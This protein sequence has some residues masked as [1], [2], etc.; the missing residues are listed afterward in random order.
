M[1]GLYN[2]R[3]VKEL[4]SEALKVPNTKNA[5][6]VLDMDG[7]KGIND[8]LGHLAGD[9]VI[10]DMALSLQSVFRKTDI[11]GRIGGDEFV[12]LLRDIKDNAFI[13]EYCIKLRQ[14]LRR[15]FKPMNKMLKV[16]GSVGITLG[17]QD[18]IDYDDLF[19]KADAALYQA[20][21]NGR[22][23]QVFYSAD[24]IEKQQKN[25]LVPEEKQEQKNFLERPVEYIFRMLYETKLSAFCWKI[26]VKMYF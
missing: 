11:L 9:A 17:P 1:T 10:I 19:A 25:E 23:T 15:S 2:K 24:I 14:M 8:N 22:D 6:L 18:G 12:V 7:F 20:K 16:T 13:I 5:L 4:I 26:L 21:E 3:R